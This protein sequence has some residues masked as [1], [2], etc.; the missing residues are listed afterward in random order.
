MATVMKT[1]LKSFYTLAVNFH[2]RSIDKIHRC[3]LVGAMLIKEMY[4]D[5]IIR[6]FTIPGT[7]GPL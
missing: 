7:V 2:T 3:E 5:I 6:A 4:H 1:K